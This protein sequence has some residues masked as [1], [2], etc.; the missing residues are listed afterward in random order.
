MVNK[1]AGGSNNTGLYIGFA[2]FLCLL[3]LAL[4]VFMLSRKSAPSEKMPV[5]TKAEIDAFM[6]GGGTPTSNVNCQAMSDNTLTWIGHKGMAS[7]QDWA[8]FIVQKCSTFPRSYTENATLLGTYF[9]NNSRAPPNGDPYLS[10]AQQVDS[11]SAT[12]SIGNPVCQKH[13]KIT[14]TGISV[15]AGSNN[16]TDVTS[17]SYIL[18]FDASYANAGNLCVFPKSSNT[19]T[20]CMFPQITLVQSRSTHNVN[21]VLVGDD[22]QPVPPGT[23]TGDVTA[24]QQ[25]QLVAGKFKNN[26]D[27]APRFMLLKDDGTFCMYRGYPGSP[28]GNPIACI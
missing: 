22:G 15:A 14:P 12:N 26:S 24:A 9:S 1:N 20:W 10:E 21:G 5:Y 27:N 17:S 28:Q 7:I 25:A 8:G 6:A 19:P 11:S 18:K 4:G 3:L 23:P 16:S 2:V 13:I